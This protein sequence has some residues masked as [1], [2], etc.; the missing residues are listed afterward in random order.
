[1]NGDFVDPKTGKPDDRAWLDHQIGLYVESHCNKSQHSFVVA[2]EEDIFNRFAPIH[3][4]FTPHYGD[5]PSWKNKDRKTKRA[6]IEAS[7]TRLVAVGKLRMVE[8]DPRQNISFRSK[9]NAKTEV[10]RA[11]TFG[12]TRTVGPR[13]FKPGTVLDALVDALDEVS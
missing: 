2:R 6:M 11:Q 12:S 7:I 1:M 13:C 3:N 4:T 8:I 9:S 5:R 10:H